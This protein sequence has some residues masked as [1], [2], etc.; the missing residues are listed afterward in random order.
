MN[1]LVK[2]GR[3]VNEGRIFDGNVVIEDGNIIDITKE[4]PESSFDEIIDASGCYVLPGVIDDHVHFREPALRIFS[5][6][7]PT[8]SSCPFSRVVPFPPASPQA[9]Y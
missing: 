4:Q 5:A 6:G 9:A 3:I 2:G 7:L 8:N 1:I